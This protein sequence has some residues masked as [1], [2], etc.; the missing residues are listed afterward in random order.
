MTGQGPF[1]S[2]S[3]PPT[4]KLRNSSIRAW[5]RC[6]RSGPWKPSAR[7]CK[8]PHSIPTAP[9]PLLGNRDGGGGRL[10]PALSAGHG[11]APPKKRRQVTRMRRP[12]AA[13]PRGGSRQEGAGAERRSRQ[14]HASREAVHRRRSRAPRSSV[15]DRDAAYIAGLRAIASRI[16][17]RSGS[18]KLSGAPPDA[19]LHH[20]RQ[21][22]P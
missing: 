3:R 7:S 13:R 6:T 9:M 4:H 22:A 19:R 20:A 1:T 8:P 16:S 10:S 15:A 11:D 12:V 5:R 21:A 18:Q 2:P 17:P 14:S